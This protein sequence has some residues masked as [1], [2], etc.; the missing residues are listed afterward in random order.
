KPVFGAAFSTS[1]RLRNGRRLMRHLIETLDASTAAVNTETGGPAQPPRLSNLHRFLPYAAK[2]GRVAV[3]KISDRLLS[4]PLLAQSAKGDPVRATARGDVV[5]RMD[6]GRPLR[7]EQM[8]CG[9][10]FKREAL[11]DLLARAGEPA[12]AETAL[13]GRILT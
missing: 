10:L 5:A 11:N 13:L 6:D 2:R 4:H 8:R 1:Y 9:R 12:L 7:W 3:T